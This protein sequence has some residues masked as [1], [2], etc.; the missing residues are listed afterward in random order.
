VTVV[1]VVGKRSSDASSVGLQFSGEQAS[2]AAS[3]LVDATSNNAAFFYKFDQGLPLVES[4]V[5]SEPP[6]SDA[7]TAFPE[8]LVTDVN[9]DGTVNGADVSTVVSNEWGACSQSAPCVGD[10]NFDGIVD[11]FDLVGVFDDFNRT[12]SIETPK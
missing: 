12:S 8:H 4:V 11:I 1:V 5:V 7:Q 10:T 9:G 3:Q 6:S 2:M